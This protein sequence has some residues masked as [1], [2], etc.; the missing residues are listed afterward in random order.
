MLTRWVCADL[1]GCG[2]KRKRRAGRHPHRRPGPAALV[3][4]N[5]AARVRRGTRLV[6]QRPVHVLAVALPGEVH[7][8]GAGGLVQAPERHQRCTVSGAAAGGQAYIVRSR[9]QRRLSPPSA[10][11]APSGLCAA[12]SVP[13]GA[14]RNSVPIL[15]CTVPRYIIFQNLP[16]FL[17][18]I[19]ASDV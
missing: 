12:A 3:Q 14:V 2:S 15:A 17:W 4:R 10:G 19:S 8:D 13:G 1:E 11:E 16:V 7:R 18:I 9:W 6:Q 5:R